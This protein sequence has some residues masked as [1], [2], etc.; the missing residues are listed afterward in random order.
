MRARFFN[1]GKD[2]LA[3]A[4]R[5]GVRGVGLPPVLEQAALGPAPWRTLVLALCLATVV[6]VVLDEVLLAPVVSLAMGR[7]WRRVVRYNVD[8]RLGVNAA[9]FGVSRPWSC[10]SARQKSWRSSP[11]S[12]T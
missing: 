4:G 1:A 2:T 6:Y 9:M 3:P 11:S 10:T 12:S 5:R 7:P 8:V